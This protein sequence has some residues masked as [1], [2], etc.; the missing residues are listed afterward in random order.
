M[1]KRFINSKQEL[2]ASCNSFNKY[3]ESDNQFDLSN[4]KKMLS[5]HCR[6]VACKKEGNYIFT[7]GSYAAYYDC[8]IEERLKLRQK[9]NCRGSNE[10]L[11]K[12]FEVI[13]KT[14]NNIQYDEFL[15]YF[16]YFR[17]S[18]IDK[19]LNPNRK[20]SFWKID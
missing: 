1:K 7:P 11:D 18:Y 15:K 10:H 17:N 12:H 16:L 5:K 14:Q 19:P 9:E 2:F 3:L 8:S 4:A 6:F 13:S 20:I